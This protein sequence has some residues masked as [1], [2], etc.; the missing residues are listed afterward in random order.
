MIWLYDKFINYSEDLKDYVEL[1][2]Y[3]GIF[4]FTRLC[5]QKIVN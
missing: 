4:G 5:I 2:E 3:D 1:K